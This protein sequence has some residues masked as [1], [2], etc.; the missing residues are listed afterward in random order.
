MMRV[1]TLVIAG[2]MLA[3]V[4]AAHAD[5]FSLNYEAPGVQNSTATFS[6]EG[7]ETFDTLAVG[8]D[9]F[10]TDFGTSG[11]ITGSYSDV[12]I[13]PADQYGGAGGTGNYAVA[14][15]G[16]PY[17]VNLTANLSKDPKGINY[18]GYWLS[19]LDG[20]NQVTFLRNGV[21]VGALNP[22]QILS[23]I[24]TNTAYNGNPNNPYK[25]WNAGQVYA[26]VNFYD[27]TGTFDQVTFDENP[28]EGGYESDNHTV[29]YYTAIG[30]VPEPTTWALMLVGF[31]ALG[32]GM[33]ASRRGR[34]AAVAG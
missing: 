16:S 13:L 11:A 23:E 19:A 25:D 22:S 9:T 32:A 8:N 33:R 26:F 31:G 24:S 12:K 29:G 3:G 30:G 15:G 7:V 27:T 1:P 17:T 14:F 21:E 4:G 18:F 34:Y 10:T 20:G 6:V 5:D 28:S 2:A